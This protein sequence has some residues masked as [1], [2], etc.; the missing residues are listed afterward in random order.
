[1]KVGI[2]FAGGGVRGAAHLGIL[3]ALEEN[4]IKADMYAGTSAGSIVATMKALGKTNEECLK[5]MEEA[6]SDLID[7]AYWDIIKNLPNKFAELDGLLKGDKLK[8]Y[9]IKHLGESFLRNVKHPLSVISTDINTGSQVVFSSYCFSKR[10]LRLIDDKIKG[11]DRY[12]PL[13]LPY[14]VYASCT[15][16]GIF[17]PMTYDSMKLVDGCLTNNLP[18]NMLKLMGADKVIAIDLNQRNPKVKKVNG[19]FNILGQSTA[20]LIDQNELLSTGIASDSIVLRPDMTE[21]GQLDF[22]RVKECYEQGYRYGLSIV[23]KVK[24]SL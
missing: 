13:A 24:E 14:I 16:P 12:S 7:I 6:N 9:L 23:T 2:A 21:F 1:M 11:Y 17:Q 8:K 15:V 4:G 10:E 19:L 22:N 3:Q 18:A 5:M 20:V